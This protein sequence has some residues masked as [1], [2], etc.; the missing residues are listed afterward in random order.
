M[1]R[2]WPDSFRPLMQLVLALLTACSE[3]PA[4]PALPA[5][6]PQATAIAAQPTFVAT[7]APTASAT[8][9]P[10]PTASAVPSATVAPSATP[11]PVPTATPTPEPTVEPTA[12]P[13]PLG[14]GGLPYPLKTDSLQYGVA[15]HLFYTS[16]TLPLRRAGEAGFGW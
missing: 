15:A 16:R 6:Q 1:A 11:T 2:R 9:A 8:P 7:S 4:A 13:Q 5:T 3:T 14:P 12:T 10:S